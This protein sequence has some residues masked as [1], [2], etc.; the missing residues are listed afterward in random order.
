MVIPKQLQNPTF[1][2]V[3]LG[4]WDVVVKKQGQKPLYKGKAPFEKAWQKN[5]YKYN[6]KK[7][8]NH[9]NKGLNYGIIGGYGKLCIVDVDTEELGKQLEQDFDTFT[10]KTG[11]GGR[12][13][14]FIVED[15]ISNAVLNDEKG[16]IRA[17]NYQVVCPPCRHPSGKYYKIHIDKPIKKVTSNFILGLLKPYL[18]AGGID[19]D[20]EFTDRIE[21]KDTSRSGLEY[22]KILALLRTGKSREEIYKEMGA[23]SKWKESGDAYKTATFEKAENFYLQEQDQIPETPKK[24]LKP[25]KKIFT[26]LKDIYKKYLDTTELNYNLLTT[27]T[28]GTYFHEQ[29]ETFPLITIMARKR[30][31]KTRALKLNSSLSYASDGSISTSVTETFL[32]RH[33]EG[34][35]FFDEMESISSRE[36]T[37]LRETINAVYK[38]GNKIVR[39][40]EKKVDGKRQYVEENFYPFYPLALANIYGFGDVLA[41]RSLQI[42]LQR[43]TK[44]QTKLVEDFATNPDILNLK[45]RLSQ[46]DVAIPENIFTSWNEYIEKGKIKEY[47][48]L[49]EKIHETKLEGRPLELFLPM[50]LIAEKFG[51]LDVLIKTAEEYMAMQ[52]GEGVDNPDDLLQNFMDKYSVEGFVNSSTI[53]KDFK[54][55]IEEPEEWM[56][57]KWF[58]RALKRLGLI[59][60]K[61]LVNGRVQVELNNNTTNTTYTTNTTNTTKSTKQVESVELVELKELV[62]KNNTINFENSGIKEMVENG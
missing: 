45:D 21:G 60:R 62:D 48:E 50:F 37:A 14:Y 40:A 43:S 5:G 36:K 51:V 28:L 7:L 56:N 24:T 26:E 22:R 53:L 1:R 15:K 20:K 47:T 57:S 54:N 49:F 8:L 27:W 42:I 17:E 31:G 16:E 34:A 18:R 11:G 3:L 33:K 61:R 10:V 29:F 25:T 13:F 55:S 44:K 46:L 38:R 35:L 41:D 59:K 32:F 52:E 6:D 58:G 12:H 2:F 4:K 23:Y 39:Y 9:I 30:S 19:L